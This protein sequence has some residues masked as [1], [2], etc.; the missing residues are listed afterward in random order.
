MWQRV[1]RRI[2]PRI[3]P[4]SPLE[5]P[6]L[7]K[8]AFITLL[9]HPTLSAENNITHL[10]SCHNMSTETI[11]RALPGNFSNPMS[12]HELMTYHQMPECW[13]HRGVSCGYPP[14]YSGSPN[15]VHTGFCSV[16]RE[17]SGQ[18]RSRHPR[19]RRGY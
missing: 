2:S 3:K 15:V 13:G 5:P 17:Y 1:A 6:F 16:S 11:C 10:F 9:I 18:F 14:I 7:T 12:Q 8:L 19:W 4:L